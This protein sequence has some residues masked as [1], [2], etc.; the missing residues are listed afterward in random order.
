MYDDYYGPGSEEYDRD[1]YEEF[2]RDYQESQQEYEQYK[3]EREQEQ[4]MY[5][6]QDALEET[7]RDADRENCYAD[8]SGGKKPEMNCEYSTGT[9]SSKI[10][11]QSNTI[12]GVSIIIIV[13]IIAFF[14]YKSSHKDKRY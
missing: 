10:S 4:Q 12:A 9:S 7:L 8:Y 2:Q 6:E 1:M 5:E 3:W 14:I 13:A 11:S